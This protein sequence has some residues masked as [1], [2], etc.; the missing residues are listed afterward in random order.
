M[1]HTID[2]LPAGYHQ[3]RQLD[4]KKRW[5]Q[6]LLLV[7]AS[8]IALGTVQ[9]RHSQARL[10]AERDRLRLQADAMAAQL[11]NAEALRQE[12]L[13]LD[14]SAA[15]LA[16]LQLRPAGTRVLQ[17]I[18]QSLPAFVSLKEIRTSH[19]RTASRTPASAADR[20]AKPKDVPAAGGTPQAA[21]LAKLMEQQR[22]SSLVV[23]LAGIAPDD[24]AVSA[25]LAALRRTQLFDDVQLL[26]TDLHVY[27]EERL[28]RFGLRLKVRRLL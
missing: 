18:A 9:Q 19:E 28:R 21:D 24:V 5:R 2:F 27:R 6:G 15:L 10:V 23:S 25:Y 3:R 13:D 26:Y 16:R 1:T 17:A 7:F 11:G 4:L 8:L 20:A 22:E 14:A 12:I